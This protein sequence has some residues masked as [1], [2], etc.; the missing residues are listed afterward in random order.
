MSFHKVDFHVVFCVACC[1][2][3]ACPRLRIP[4]PL[5]SGT[6]RPEDVRGYLAADGA[7][8]DWEDG[9]C[10]R[11]VPRSEVAKIRIQEAETCGW[12][13]NPEVKDQVNF[14]LCILCILYI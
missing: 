11:R 14:S 9:D 3:Y 5:L 7:A 13:V 10:W 6:F 12:A 8:I 1:F 4:R 2:F